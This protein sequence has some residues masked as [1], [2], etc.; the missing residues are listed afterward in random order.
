M[1][2]THRE[3]IRR[4]C[5][6][7]EPVPTDVAPRPAQLDGIRAVLFDVYG[8]LLIS[9]SGDVGTA[10][11]FSRGDAFAEALAA[12]GIETSVDG[13][14]GVVCLLEAIHDQ[15]AKARDKGVEFPEVDI[16]AVWQRTLQR[17]DELGELT[18]DS[19]GADVHRLALEYECRTNPV[20]PMPQAADCLQQL[21]EHGLDLGIVS[22][23]Q[24]FTPELFEPLLGGGLDELGFDSEL[25]FYSYRF[26]Q[27]KPGTFLFERALEAL[28]AR[29]VSARE[30]L[31]IGNDMLND[32]RPAA[33]VGFHTALFAGDARSLRMRSGDDRVAGISPEVVLTDLGQLPSCVANE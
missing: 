21:R 5:V 28:A 30:V 32:V 7:L 10:S 13:E 27:A 1:T 9:D 20:W 22:N 12:V 18:G 11:E 17:L 19:A 24:F 16:C 2:V 8:T 31:Y 23:A 3:I 4:R 15:Q 29:G 33:A 26:G 6:A 25:C 14:Q